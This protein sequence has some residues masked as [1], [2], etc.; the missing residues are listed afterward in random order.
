MQ[1]INL[2]GILFL[3]LCLSLQQRHETQHAITIINMTDTHPT[4]SKSCRLIWQLRPANQGW[5]SQRTFEGPFVLSPSR[6]H[7]PFLLQRSHSVVVA[8]KIVKNKIKTQSIIKLFAEGFGTIHLR[9]RL[10]LRGEW[11]PHGPMF[12][13]ARGEGF[14]GCRHQ[15]CLKLSGDKF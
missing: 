9:R 6:T 8:K 3:G 2:H 14:Q 10:V 11:G 4:I 15:Q 12:A 13:D 5:H 7:F 1:K